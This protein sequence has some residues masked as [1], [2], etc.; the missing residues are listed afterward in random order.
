MNIPN[1]IDS[2]AVDEKGDF[3]EPWKHTLNQL[4]NELQ[5]NMSNESHIV[6]SQDTSNITT[7][8]VSDYAGGLIYNTDTKKLMVN[9][10][11]T[12][13]EVVTT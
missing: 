3:T 11:G 4:F 2:K 13:K 6:P 10:D 7:L 8:N 1:F 5:T 12:F 9:I